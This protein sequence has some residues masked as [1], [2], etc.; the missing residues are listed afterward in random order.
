[1]GLIMKS[2]PHAAPK[3]KKL[4]WFTLI[5]CGGISWFLSLY[6]AFHPPIDPGHVAQTLDLGKSVLAVLYG[7]VPVVV[8]GILSDRLSKGGMGWFRIAVSCAILALSMAFSISAQAATLKEFAGEGLNWLFPLMLDITTFM[9]LYDLMPKRRKADEED[10]LT[11]TDSDPGE[12]T[13]TLTRVVS[14]GSVTPSLTTPGEGHRALT[15]PPARPL[16]QPVS[17]PSL[18]PHS[19]GPV[20]LTG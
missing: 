20:T 8:A 7:T 15:A 2:A 12:G 18:K 11:A 4:A 10:T 3:G 6:H 1:M 19:D 14:E 16:T 17:D 13:V 9:A 5:F